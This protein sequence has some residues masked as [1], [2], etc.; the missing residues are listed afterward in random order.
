M[1]L[2]QR[3][4]QRFAVYRDRH[5]TLEG[6]Y[7]V[8]AGLAVGIF[9]LNLTTSQS[10]VFWSGLFALGL[11]AFISN[12][13][14]RFTICIK[15]SIP[16]KVAADTVVNYSVV[17]ENTGTKDILNLY[18]RE[19][20]APWNVRPHHERLRG[21]YIS[22]IKAGESI[23]VKMQAAFLHRGVYLLPTVRAEYID[24][25]GLT[26]SGRSFQVED[27]VTVYPRT[28]PVATVE[29]SRASVY[30][31]GGVP[32]AAS[33]GESP[34]F[35]SLRK[36][37]AGDPIR[38][39]SWKAWA[40]HGQPIVREFQGEYF[41][42]V[43]VILDTQ[44]LKGPN[45]DFEAAVSLVA[46]V[47]QY[48]EDNEYI[49]DIFA[50]GPRVYYLCTG[51]SLGHVDE[52]LEALANV[53]HCRD[54]SF[55]HIDEGLRSLFGR[56]SALVLITT[57]WRNDSKDFYYK[58]RESVPE[59]NLMLM[60]SSKPHEDPGKDIEDIRL[61]RKLDPSELDGRLLEL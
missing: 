7:L 59:V 49:I 11:T 15:R 8:L 44:M 22:R 32:L 41:R 33:V 12:S 45:S 31:P 57:D 1:S 39:L 14:H 53:E 19:E 51:M 50:A 40:R 16:K 17:V 10:Y 29:L 3:L 56:L 52:V 28:Y 23:E 6:I 55:P 13:F 18:V 37:Q 4:N 30:Q 21:G 58:I 43:A 54:A 27:Q 61:L 2:Y 34:E 60:G 35:R 46:S 38:H 25:F 36:Y 9:S 26:R 24:S 48:F 42:R 47:A 5:L 20:N